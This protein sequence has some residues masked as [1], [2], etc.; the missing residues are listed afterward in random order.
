MKVWLTRTAL[1]QGII[2]ADGELGQG[3]MEGYLLTGGRFYWGREWHRTKEAA[4]A[5]AEEMRAGK[6]ASLRKQIAKLEKLTSFKVTK[7]GAK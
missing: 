3:H 6:I 4:I 5:R 2:E 1:T 7:R